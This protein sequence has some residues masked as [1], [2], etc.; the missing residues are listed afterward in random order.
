MYTDTQQAIR[1]SLWNFMGSLLTA[2][3]YE[4][5]RNKESV[6][7]V[8]SEELCKF[9]KDEND[10][11]D[12]LAAKP[13]LKSSIWVLQNRKAEIESLPV[14]SEAIN[15]TIEELDNLI[16]SLDMYVNKI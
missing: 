13:I 5:K 4:D 1:N 12:I 16:A 7:A 9:C 10:K 3:M 6:T 2:S 15:K 14:K 11:I 8:F